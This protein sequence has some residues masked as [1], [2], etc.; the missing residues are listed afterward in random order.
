MG[1]MDKIPYFSD[2]IETNFTERNPNVTIHSVPDGHKVE[3]GNCCL[4]EIKINK[5]VLSSTSPFLKQCLLDTTDMA[6]IFVNAKPETL[7]ML[8]DFITKGI[9]GFDHK[10][11]RNL[12]F[13][14]DFLA[15][16][17]NLQYLDIIST[18]Y[19]DPKNLMEDIEKNESNLFDL[20][21]KNAV[22]GFDDLVAPCDEN[23]LLSEDFKQ[24]EPFIKVGDNESGNN[25]KHLE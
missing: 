12:G 25:L 10:A 17:I 22:L 8:S 18:S 16:G 5:S 19:E 1:T 9:L 14:V 21:H 3:S 4:G 11:P 2:I 20:V 15:F 24:V 23:N 13:L 6:H 7:E